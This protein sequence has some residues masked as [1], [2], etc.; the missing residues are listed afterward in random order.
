MSVVPAFI[1]ATT[2]VLVLGLLGYAGRDLV[3]SWL[4]GLW[5]SEIKQHKKS[6]EWFGH[7]KQRLREAAEK[8]RTVQERSEALEECLDLVVETAEEISET[9]AD[10]QLVPGDLDTAAL[11]EKIDEVC[12]R[13]HNIPPA[14]ED[15]QQ[16][17]CEFETSAPHVQHASAAHS[18]ELLDA[19]N[20]NQITQQVSDSTVRDSAPLVSIPATAGSSQEAA[21]A[22]DCP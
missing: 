6:K 15:L 3:K 8:L 12:S 4:G 9:A 10:A 22:R 2:L 7:M 19:G 17:P 5:A 14:F 21:G 11:L 13:C 1:G 20:N 16:A 18:M